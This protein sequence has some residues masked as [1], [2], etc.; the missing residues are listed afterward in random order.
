MRAGAG[1]SIPGMAA[2]LQQFLARV[3]TRQRAVLIGGLAVIAHGLSRPTKDGDAWLDPLGSA[4]EWARVLIETL[5]EFDGLKLWSLAGR[6][7]LTEGEIGAEAADSGVLRV[8]GLV[9][10]L[11]LF[12]KPNVFEC[13]D[14]DAVWQRAAIWAEDVRVIDPLDLILTKDSTGRD[15]DMHDIHFLESKIRADLGG[16]LATATLAEAEAIFARY[17]DHVVCE[18]ALANPDAAV[19]ERAKGLLAELAA[20]GDWFARDVLARESAGS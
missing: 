9:A 11:D 13:E 5:H 8:C 20:E 12:R 16:R 19:R 7:P 6:H 2:T 10:D 18:R 3:A 14:F 1:G 15:Q 17:V 4:D